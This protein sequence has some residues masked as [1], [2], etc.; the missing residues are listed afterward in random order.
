M[1]TLR[2][3]LTVSLFHLRKN[4][5]IATL[6]RMHITHTTVLKLLV[7][8]FHHLDSVFFPYVSLN[9]EFSLVLPIDIGV[10]MSFYNATGGPAWKQNTAWLTPSG[11][12]DPCPASGG[13]DYASAW[14]GIVC[15]SDATVGEM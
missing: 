14:F 2:P 6:T 7:S 8:Y 15:H 10:L 5:V 4:L 13:N 9:T 1:H 3:T 12:P 11:N